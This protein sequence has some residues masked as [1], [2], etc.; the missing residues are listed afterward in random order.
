MEADAPSPP[1]HVDADPGAAML[2]AQL[3]PSGPTRSYLVA[4][5]RS[6]AAML[7][8]PRRDQVDRYLA[9]LQR[10]GLRLELVLDTHTHGD[11]LS[12]AKRL[13]DLLGCEIAMHRAAAAPCVDR[14]L[15]D[16]DTITL[17]DLALEVWH[18]PATP[19]TRCASSCP[20]VSSPATLCGSAAPAAATSAA[21]LPPSPPACC[22]CAACL[23]TPRC[24]R[25][26]T[27]T[28]AGAP[29]SA[30][31]P[32]RTRSSRATSA[33]CALAWRRT[34]AKPRRSA[35]PTPPVRHDRSD[36]PHGPC[37]SGHAPGACPE[38]HPLTAPRSRPP[39]TTRRGVD[40]RREQVDVAQAGLVAGVG[41]EV[42]LLRRRRRRRVGAEA[43]G[44][45]GVAADE[46]DAKRPVSITGC[47]GSEICSDPELTGSP[48]DSEV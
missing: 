16:G 30:R 18:T 5:R 20:T 40:L 32:G 38:R 15:E 17:G 3:N 39:G 43:D 44:R 23:R 31:R 4:D 33:S 24:G 9:E 37:P 29:P 12:G 8:D 21:I 27:S 36:M 42:A 46:A 34:G 48:S 41:A 1:A 25:C 26:T 11:H 35:G 14:P 13:K 7:V 6:G 10:H 45:L 2:F 28:A 47:C 22:G 19:P